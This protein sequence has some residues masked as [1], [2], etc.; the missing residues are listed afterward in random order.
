[1]P[2][3]CFKPCDSND[4]FLGITLKQ[5]A[6]KLGLCIKTRF[7]EKVNEIIGVENLKEERH[8]A[9]FKSNLC[10]MIKDMDLVFSTHSFKEWK[11]VEENAQFK[12]KAAI[13]SKTLEG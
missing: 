1:M 9:L 4:D 8:K 6:I 10:K 2:H 3:F 5:L 13:F 12:N 7:Q 11:I